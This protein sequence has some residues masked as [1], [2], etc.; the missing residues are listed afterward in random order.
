MIN[1]SFEKNVFVNCPFDDKYKPLLNVLLFVIY[2]C[3]FIPRIATERLSSSESR[4]S[5]IKDLIKESQYSIHDISRCKSNK[6]GEYYRLNMPFEIGLDFG[7]KTYATGNLNNKESLL[8]VS[9]KY[10]HQKSLSDLAGVDVLCHDDN[11][12]NLV[13]CVRSW[14][15]ERATNKSKIKNPTPIWEDFNNYNMFLYERYKADSENLDIPEYM[16]NIKNYLNIK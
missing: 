16:N 12:E 1:N 3:G 2:S 14:L 6:K 7:C 15:Y 9:E 13:K 8:L 5:K 4:L 10:S 11:P